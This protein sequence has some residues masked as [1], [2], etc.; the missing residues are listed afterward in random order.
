M[1]GAEYVD[2]LCIGSG[3][4]GVAAGIAEAAKGLKVFVAEPNETVTAPRR[5]VAPSV[6]SWA[7]LLQR[8]WGAEEVNSATADYLEEMTNSLGPPTPVK[9]RDQLPFDTVE[10]FSEVKV[11]RGEEAPP[12]FGAELAT[13]AR[14]CLTSPSGMIFSQIRQPTLAEVRKVDGTT[15]R[16]GVVARVPTNRRREMTVRQWL[17]ELA[18]DNG[19]T[20]SKSCS[21]QRLLFRE[22]QLT[23]AVLDTPDGARAIRARLGVVL[24]TN[25]SAEDEALA[26]MP[27]AERG[28]AL[29][30]VGRSASR[31]ARLEFLVDKASQSP[32]A[33]PA[34]GVRWAQTP[35]MRTPELMSTES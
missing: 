11:D 31:F 12:F 33:P 8:R 15:I 17:S 23:G 9:V 13:W 22:G 18:L 20:V 26:M 19:L 3:S 6:E 4:A 5:P 7:T 30:I 24:G 16:A 28:T 29:C 1:G 32:C 21:V 10:T 14:D 34:R 2:I 35:V 27:M 25:C